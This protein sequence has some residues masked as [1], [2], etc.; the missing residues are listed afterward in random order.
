MPSV[1]CANELGHKKRHMHTLTLIVA[2]KAVVLL[3]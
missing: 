1:Q 3:R 2:A